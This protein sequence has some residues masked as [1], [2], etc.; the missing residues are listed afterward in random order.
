VDVRSSVQLYYIAERQK[1]LAMPDASRQV[2]AQAPTFDP[3]AS[4]TF[5]GGPDDAN[6]GTGTCSLAEISPSTR[7]RLH[8]AAVGCD[9][10]EMLLKCTKL[11]R[12]Y[13][14][15]RISSRSCL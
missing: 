2:G 6:K 4:G 7:C 5:Q 11:L 14:G 13:A 8:T 3:F 1:V 10:A 12:R 9:L 15:S